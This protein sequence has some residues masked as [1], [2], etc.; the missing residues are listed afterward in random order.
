[1]PALRRLL[2]RRS[3]F[4]RKKCRTL[5]VVAA[6]SIGRIGGDEAYGVLETYARR[7]DAA[8]RDACRHALYQIA[9]TVGM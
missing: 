2:E 6:Q 8:V 4:G 5:R 7:G 1:M 3:L 9:R